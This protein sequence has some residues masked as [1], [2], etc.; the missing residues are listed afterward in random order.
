[1]LLGQSA[2]DVEQLLAMLQRE[3]MAPAVDDDPAEE[4][5]AEDGAARDEVQGEDKRRNLSAFLV[6]ERN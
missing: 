4:R 3:G 1:M 5:P 6:Q 2:E